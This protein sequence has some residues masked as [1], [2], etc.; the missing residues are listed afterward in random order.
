[1][2]NASPPLGILYLASTL[3]SAGIEVSALDNATPGSSIKDAVDWAVKEDPDILGLSTV[4]T[5]SLTAPMIAREVKKKNPNVTIVFGNHHATFN[6]ERILGKYPF[7]DMIVRG[8]GEHTCLEL[9]NRLKK[10]RSLKGVLGVTFRHNGRIASNPDR[11]LIKDV[12]SLP[13]PDRSLVDVEYHNTTV[14]INVAPR[15]FTSFLSSRGCVFKCR[16][17]S[18]ASIARNFWRPR[19]IENI[20]EELHL[21]ASEGYEQIMLVDDN[22]TLN[23]KRV[24]ELCRRMKKEKI[25][26]GWLSEGRVDQGSYSM[27]RSMVKAGC[28]MMYFGIESGTQKVLDYYNK[29]IT[30]E[31]SERAVANARKAGVDIIV[32]S[33][34]IGAPHETE[35]DIQETLNFARRLQLDIPQINVLGSFPGNLIWKEFKEKGFLN[36]DKYWETGVCISDI[37]PGTVPLDQMREMIRIFYHRLLRSPRFLIKQML[38]TAGSSYRLNVAFNILV[39]LSTVRKSVGSFTSM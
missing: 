22:F 23:Q 36:E 25:E 13:F 21:L 15:K 37:Y 6:A 24:I 3:K 1:M 2:I 26:M 10:K 38:L 11:P 32:G 8:E 28:R 30:P 12:D 16:F 34:I 39:R 31:Q 29:R 9:V 7:V 14:G 27:F 18:C 35:N 4:I 17:C 19:S 33:F 5:S 20:L